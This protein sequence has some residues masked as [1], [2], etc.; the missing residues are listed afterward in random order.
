M[1]LEAE[2]NPDEAG[3]AVDRGNY[4]TKPNRELSSNRLEYLALRARARPDTWERQSP[5]WQGFMHQRGGW[6]ST[7]G[8]GILHAAATRENDRGGAM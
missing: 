2:I 4:Q 1:R 7:E 5:D 6:R 8:S 3:S